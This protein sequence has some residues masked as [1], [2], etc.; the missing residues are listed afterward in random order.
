MRSQTSIAILEVRVE[1][2]SFVRWLLI[3]HVINWICVSADQYR[4]SL[5]CKAGPSACSLSA[6]LLH[7]AHQIF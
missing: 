3:P 7:Q 2:M 5:I 1:T 4:R 6:M